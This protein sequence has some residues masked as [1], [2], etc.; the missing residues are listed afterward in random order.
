M[1]LLLIICGLTLL[2]LTSL[3]VLWTTIA[4]GQSGGPITNRICSQ[5]WAAALRCHRRLASHHFLTLVG[6]ATILLTA[7]TWILL[8]FV[9][10]VL[11]FCASGD[12]LVSSTSEQPADFWDRVYFTGYTLVTLGLGDYKPKGSIWQL[13]T[14]LEAGNGF[15]IVTLAITYLIAV[16]AAV[17]QKRQLALYISCLGRTP[18]EIVIQAWNG[19]DFGGLTQHLVTLAPLLTLYGQ[20]HL[21]Y[22]VLHYCHS[23]ERQTT[24]EIYI[25]VLDEALTLLATGVKPEHRPDATTLYVTRQALTK[26]LDTLQSAFIK[27]TAIAPPLP[28]LEPLRANGIPTVSDEDF[29]IAVDDIQKRR[30]LLLALVK[31]DGWSWEA[32]RAVGK[33]LP[34]L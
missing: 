28:R 7:L 9:S 16:A 30:Q 26:F 18:E 12:S 32:V 8:T 6:Y 11:I 4:V 19:N 14:V 23:V 10:W 13:A 27:P 1:Q 33:F 34:T 24:A 25:A 29:Q 5:V 22:P 17:T 2:G 15:F 31:S 21:A 20:S 3:D